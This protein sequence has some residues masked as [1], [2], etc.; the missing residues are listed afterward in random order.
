[1]SIAATPTPSKGIS[2]VLMNK[3]KNS[4]PKFKQMQ[5]LAQHDN[6]MLL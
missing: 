3:K 5:L 1:M 6:I 4:F 2:D